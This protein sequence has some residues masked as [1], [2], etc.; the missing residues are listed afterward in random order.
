MAKDWFQASFS[1][2]MTPGDQR[3]INSVQGTEPGF[4]LLRTLAYIE[5]MYTD[6]FQPQLLGAPYLPLIC[7]GLLF[8]Y[9]LDDGFPNDFEPTVDDEPD[10]L[11]WEQ[12]HW[13]YQP[14]PG[15]DSVTGVGHIGSGLIDVKGQ[16]A[17]PPGFG[18][19]FCMVVGHSTREADPSSAVRPSWVCNASMRWLMDI[20]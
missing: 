19:L 14:T 1:D 10:W 20:G 17:I 2:I 12:I 13:D 4:T 5:C 15:A 9:N 11:F 16:R 7:A 18:G 6:T 3:A 8:T